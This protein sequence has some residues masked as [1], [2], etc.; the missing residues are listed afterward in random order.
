MILS[1]IKAQ[2]ISNHWKFRLHL[3]KEF[4]AK[5]LSKKNFFFFLKLPKPSKKPS[6]AFFT[7]ITHIIWSWMTKLYCI[8]SKCYIF[9]LFCHFTRLLL[10]KWFCYFDYT[11]LL[12]WRLRVFF[13]SWDSLHARLSNH[14]KAWCYKKSKHKKIR[15]YRKYF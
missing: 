7:S 14:Y 8:F 15:G 1:A 10:K 12:C 13:L 4:N 5:L 9:I 2:Q 6:W 3:E 11:G